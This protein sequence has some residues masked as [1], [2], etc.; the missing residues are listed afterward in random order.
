M[1]LCDLHRVWQTIPQPAGNAGP[2]LND[3]DQRSAQ[4]TIHIAH[5]LPDIDRF[6]LQRLLLSR[7]KKFSG[8]PRPKRDAPQGIAERAPALV[9]YPA[10]PFAPTARLS[11]QLGYRRVDF[12]IRRGLYAPP[13]GDAL[14]NGSLAIPPTMRPRR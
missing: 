4:N 6:G 11:V 14:K 13:V 12:G 1:A 10:V 2:D 8:E 7:G 9:H 3:F 5:N